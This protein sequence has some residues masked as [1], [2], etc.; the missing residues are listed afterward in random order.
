MATETMKKGK[1]NE[2][3]KRFSHSLYP[4]SKLDEVTDNIEKL[5]SMLG[6]PIIGHTTSKILLDIVNKTKPKRILEIGTL[7]GYST[8]VIGKELGRDAEIITIEIQRDIAKM[9]EENIRKAELLPTVKVIV[10][11]ARKIILDLEGEFDLVFIDAEKKE[12]LEYLRMIENKLHKH[13]VVVA[14]NAGL[15]AEGM[16][17]YLEYVRSSGKYESKY[18]ASTE[19]GIIKIAYE[20]GIHAGIDGVEVSTRL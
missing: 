13:S 12:Y 18:I 2:K 15:L 9:A 1:L 16:K 10:G 11:D 8:I 17:D 3:I 5:A 6:L 7:I 19:D 20:D 4:I 14:D